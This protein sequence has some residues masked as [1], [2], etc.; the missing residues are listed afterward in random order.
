MSNAVSP[1]GGLKKK[2]NRKTNK[3]PS[4]TF[5]QPLP[6]LHIW[7]PVVTWMQPSC[8]MP[9]RYHYQQQTESPPV[10]LWVDPYLP[11]GSL[12]LLSIMSNLSYCMSHTFLSCNRC[13]WIKL[14]GK[15]SHTLPIPLSHKWSDLYG[16]S[17]NPPR[18]ECWSCPIMPFAR[19]PFHRPRTPPPHF[20]RLPPPS[21]LPKSHQHR[22][23]SPIV[24]SHSPV[25]AFQLIGVQPR[26]FSQCA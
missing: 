21:S 10:T 25:G 18:E 12:D 9:L 22:R 14:C 1:V 20:T 5:N 4:H 24:R 15:H 19:S 7:Y 6:C 26:H 13:S 3:N 16:R 23:R 11:R 2:K 17:Q 8:Q